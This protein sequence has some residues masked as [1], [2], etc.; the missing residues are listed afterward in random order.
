MNNPD[1]TSIIAVVNLYALAVDTQHW[2]LFD[3]TFTTD[4]AAD[5]GGAAVWRDLASLKR[6]FDAIHSPFD[7]TQ[8]VTTNHNVTVQGDTAHSLSYVHG[9][10]IRQ[11]PGGNMFE[12]TGWYDDRLVRTAAG[13][14][15]AQRV[16][17]MVWWGGN[18]RVLETKGVKVEHTLNSLRGE[19]RAGRL[20]YLRAIGAQQ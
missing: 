13:W 11:V 7:A 4:V 10:F 14:R 17:R 12:S 8:H 1:S 16:C 15:I 5:F 9:R 3:Q 19:A 2:Q 6:D 18:P 20:A